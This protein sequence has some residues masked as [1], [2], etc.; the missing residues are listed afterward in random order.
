MMPGHYFCRD[1]KQAWSREPD[2][3]LMRCEARRIMLEEPHRPQLVES[4]CVKLDA[5]P[6]RRQGARL[7]TQRRALPTMTAALR[8][9][10]TRTL[11][12]SMHA[13]MLVDDL[14]TIREGVLHG[15]E[16][17]GLAHVIGGRNP[18]WAFTPLGRRLRSAMFELED[19]DEDEHRR[20]TEGAEVEP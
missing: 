5:P 8:A 3:H 2:Q 12:P 9:K 19:R 11:T 10:L 13:A 18:F 17:R 6:P 15:L 4:F 14:S 16:R 20:I 7:A 1:C